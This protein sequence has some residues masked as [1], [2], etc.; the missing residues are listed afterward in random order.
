MEKLKSSQY[1]TSYL[2]KFYVNGFNKKIYLRLIGEKKRTLRFSAE[3]CDSIISFLKEFKDRHKVD[4]CNYQK[5]QIGDSAQHYIEFSYAH[6]NNWFVD[7]K[8]VDV[9]DILRIVN[10]NDV[11]GFYLYDEDI[12]E[13]IQSLEQYHVI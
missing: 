3:Q 12:D 6:Y 2:E 13:I 10:R 8:G 5:L 7:D 1:P 11:Y 4:V 9:S